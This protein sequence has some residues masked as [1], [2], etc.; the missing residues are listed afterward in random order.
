MTVSNASIPFDHEKVWPGK[1]KIQ[2]PESRTPEEFERI[3]PIEEQTFNRLRVTGIDESEY[4]TVEGRL[5][6]SRTAFNSKG[7]CS[8][9]DNAWRGL[10]SIARKISKMGG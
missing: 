9:T 6:V 3:I 4:R 2:Q 8:P 10:K 7:D 5:F 1:S